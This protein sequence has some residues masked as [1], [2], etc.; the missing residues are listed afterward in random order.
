M[1]QE[2]RLFMRREEIQRKR[3]RHT[4]ELSRIEPI[5]NRIDQSLTAMEEVNPVDKTILVDRFVDKV[6]WEGTAR[7]ANCSVGFCRKRASVA[8]EKLT[9]MVFGPQAVPAQDSNI[10]FFEKEAK[11]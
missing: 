9:V 7:N 11:S 4:T 2:E 3:D 10:V 6:S 5:V 8:L 1:S